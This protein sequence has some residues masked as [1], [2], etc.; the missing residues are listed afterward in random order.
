MT[1]ADQIAAA[2]RKLRTAWPQML[3]EGPRAAGTGSPVAGSKE[4][5]PPAP[6][7]TLSLRRDVCTILASWCRLVIEDAVDMEGRTMTT[8]LDGSNGPQMAGWLLTWADF[9]GDHEDADDAVSELEHLAN[10]CD[11]VAREI[12]VRRFNVGPCIE[13]GVTDMGERVPCSG[14]L[15][16][17]LR[18][19]EDL[20]PHT[21]RCN[22]DPTH[23][24]DAADWR[25]LGDRIH[26][27]VTVEQATAN[28]I[29]AINGK[30]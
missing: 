9:L 13:Y 16:A 4:P 30:R 12:R 5:P 3:P 23:S 19:D 14:K 8:N 26:G 7:G 10:Q 20:L 29:A 1:K 17:V 2:L 25:R 24:W 11:A 21:L 18:S 22:A 6:I 27:T 15:V 28:L